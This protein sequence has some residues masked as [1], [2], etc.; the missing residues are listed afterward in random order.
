MKSRLSDPTP[1]TWKK[2]FNKRA[3][4]K[5]RLPGGIV[6][7]SSAAILTVY[8]LGRVNTTSGSEQLPVATSP[9]GVVSASASHASATPAPSSGATSPVAAYKNGTFTG[10][11]SSRHGGMEVTVVINGGKIVS[12][13]VTSCATRYPCS[14]VSSLVHSAVSNQKVPSSHVSGAT[15]SSKA[16]KQ[17]LTNALAKAQA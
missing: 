12:A 1:A 15:D 7:L 5:G 4:S 13:N 8:S 6:A 17:A 14:D 2:L 3:T 11:G 9:A 16:Y 10:N